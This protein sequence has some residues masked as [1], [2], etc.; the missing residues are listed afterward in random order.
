MFPAHVLIIRRSKWHYTTS[1]IIT[2]IGGH[3]MHE[4]ATYKCDDTRGCVMPFWPPDDEHMCWKHVEAWNKLIE[5][6]KFCASSWLIT[7]IKIREI[8]LVRLQCPYCSYHHLFSSSLFSSINIASCCCI[9]FFS[10]TF[11][12]YG[13]MDE[14]PP[15]SFVLPQ[16]FLL[17]FLPAVSLH[18]KMQP[19]CLCCQR[20]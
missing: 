15:V 16:T 11:I 2:P 12:L 7:E 14:K 9:S 13:L 19:R 8:T 4:I 17:D 10:K 18:P 1:G 20:Y 6:Q 3:L 5:K